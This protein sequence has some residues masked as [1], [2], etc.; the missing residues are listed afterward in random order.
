MLEMTWSSNVKC[1]LARSLYGM[2]STL[3]LIC[4]S[5]LLRTSSLVWLMSL[6]PEHKIVL[7]LQC[8]LIVIQRSSVIAKVCMNHITLYY[9]VLVS[10]IVSSVS[11]VGISSNKDIL[12]LINEWAVSFVSMYHVCSLSIHNILMWVCEV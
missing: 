2:E 11:C 7:L 9:N 4:P 12:Y 10:F 5:R 8:V 1:I 3:I 6:L